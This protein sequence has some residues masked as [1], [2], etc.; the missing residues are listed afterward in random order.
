MVA[1]GYTDIQ[2]GERGS[3][4]QHLTTIQFKAMKE[5]QHLAE[6]EAREIAAQAEAE[7]AEA[8]SRQAEAAAQKAQAKLV[9]V[10]ADVKDAEAYAKKLGDPEDLLPSPSRMESAK[11]YRESKAMPIIRKLTGVCVSLYSRLAEAKKKIVDLT[12]ERDHAAK[13]WK[14]LFD[15]MPLMQ[16]KA[17]KFDK[18]VKLMGQDEIERL[19]KQKEP[20]WKEKQQGLEQ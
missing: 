11:S 5:E 10:T 16:A 20:Q 19:M 15:E 4:E 17:T 8:E 6:I 9:Q 12:K 13:E 1:A 18:L 14:E 3:D 2:R 7:R